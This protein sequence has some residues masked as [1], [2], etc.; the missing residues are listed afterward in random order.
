[1]RKLG[2]LSG[3]GALL[4]D[5]NRVYLDLTLRVWR[6]RAIRRHSLLRTNGECLHFKQSVLRVLGFMKAFREGRRSSSAIA[7]SNSSFPHV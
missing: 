6:A 7:L 1:M 4:V 2:A 3:D 5:L